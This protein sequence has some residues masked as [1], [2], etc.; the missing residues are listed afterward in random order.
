MCT[1]GT[2]AAPPTQLGAPQLVEW[3]AR[4]PA[5]S[6]LTLDVRYSISLLRVDELPA[7]S[8]RGLELGAAEVHYRHDGSGQPAEVAYTEPVLVPVLLPDLSMPYNV[9]S[10]SSTVLALFVA[11]FRDAPPTPSGPARGG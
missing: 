8:S 5:H 7:D 1:G 2:L 6:S 4:L 10:I 9:I 11:T 3:D